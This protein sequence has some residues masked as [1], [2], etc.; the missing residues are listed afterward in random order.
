M[1]H[2]VLEGIISR[3]RAYEVYGVVINETGDINIDKTAA[4]R[5]S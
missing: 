1:R 5:S 2:D 4:L 3:E